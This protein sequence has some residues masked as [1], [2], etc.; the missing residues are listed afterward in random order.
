[1]D[2]S[3]L[4]RPLWV[5]VAAGFALGAPDARTSQPDADVPAVIS[6]K[7]QSTLKERYP[8]IEIAAIHHAP[9]PGLYE[10]VLSDQI[11]YADESANY[12]IAGR[13]VD[14]RSKQDLS[15]AH[16]NAYNA[17]DF[18]TLPLEAA[19]KTVRGNGSRKLAVFEDPHCPYCKQLEE[20]LQG[21]SDVTIY[22][23]LFPLESIH[24]GA[25]DRATR[26]WCSKDRAAAWAGWMLHQT[27][28]AAAAKDCDKGSLTQ[29]SALAEKLHINSTPTLFFSDG[30]RARGALSAEQLEQSLKAVSAKADVA[31]H[32]DHS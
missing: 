21:V 17:I 24:P 23:F 12:L 11:I 27:E 15:S 13:L 19:I 4:R 18:S 2:L 10:V 14:T 5:M 28:P 32:P 29:V 22:T 30:E 6:G 9:M 1:M 20:H 25:T 7:I 3:A 8:E 31:P 26:I 16:W